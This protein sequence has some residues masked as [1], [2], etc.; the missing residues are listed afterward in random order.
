MII[1]IKPI[2]SEA[3]RPWYLSLFLSW[4]VYTF[5]VDG[6]YLAYLRV[7]FGYFCVAQ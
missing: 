2:F 5:V 3:K 7:G 6:I 4:G 1:I